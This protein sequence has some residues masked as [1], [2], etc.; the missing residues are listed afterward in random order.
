MCP[1]SAERLHADVDRQALLDQVGQLTAEQLAQVPADQRE[2]I[3][4]LRRE[5]DARRAR[6]SGGALLG[7]SVA[8]TAAPPTTP[9]DPIPAP[10]LPRP[11]PPTVAAPTSA[12]GMESAPGTKRS[13]KSFLMSAGLPQYIATFEEEDMEVEVMREVLSRQGGAAFD[14]CLEELGVT[15]MGHRVQIANALMQR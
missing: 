10:P 3:E 9:A 5:A 14:E 13:V 11:P 15:S 2:Q 7:P 8:A 6:G 1:P 12:T 4:A